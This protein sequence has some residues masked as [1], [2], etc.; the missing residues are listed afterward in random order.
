MSHTKAEVLAE[1]K[2]RIDSTNPAMGQAIALGAAVE[3]SFSRSKRHRR[4]V[5]MAHQVNEA[6][7]GDPIITEVVAELGL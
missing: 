4:Y 1:L 5:E 3:D 2:V 7:E 6:S